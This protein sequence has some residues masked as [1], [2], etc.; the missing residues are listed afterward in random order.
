MHN[1]HAPR[2][3]TRQP[4]RPLHATR[5]MADLPPPIDL[6]HATEEY[7]HLRKRLLDWTHANRG[8]SPDTEPNVK[9][10]TEINSAAFRLIVRDRARAATNRAHTTERTARGFRALETQYCAHAFVRRLAGVLPT[11]PRVL[12]D[13][14]P[15]WVVHTSLLCHLLSHAGLTAAFP[16]LVSVLVIEQPAD[17]DTTA[18]HIDMLHLFPQR[19]AATLACLVGGEGRVGGSALFDLAETAGFG[20][21]A[22]WGVPWD[23]GV[24]TPI[25]AAPVERALSWGGDRRDKL[26]LLRV[27]N[28]YYH[29]STL[30]SMWLT[31]TLIAYIR[32]GARTQWGWAATTAEACVVDAKGELCATSGIDMLLVWL[33]RAERGRRRLSMEQQRAIQLEATLS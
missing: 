22:P 28:Q 11:S 10:Q 7:I 4:C 8:R 5:R 3:A 20:D 18:L 29:S 9:F 6:D 13:S 30:D 21:G 31:A 15:L 25:R 26:G 16:A 17:A 14:V 1:E 33:G 12:S 27:V 32:A 2:T 23:T 19:V 24:D